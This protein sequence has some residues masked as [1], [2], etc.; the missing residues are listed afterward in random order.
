MGRKPL[1]IKR[2]GQA[3]NI[4][5]TLSEIGI[6]ATVRVI[7]KKS[8]FTPTIVAQLPK[9]D[10]AYCELRI[11]EFT[12]FIIKSEKRA[13]FFMSPE[14]VILEELA[15]S[16]W[17]GTAIIAI[18]FDLDEES[19]I[20]IF[21]NMPDGI[22]TTFINEGAYPSTFRPDNGAIICP[23]IIPNGYRQYITHVCCRMMSLYRIFQGDRILFSCFPQAT[24]VPELGWSYAEYDFFN[25]IMGESEK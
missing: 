1:S 10:T 11:R 8:G 7:A 15:L 20:R 21:A 9:A 5:A 18:P 23:G 16:K 19:Q 6:L 2:I 17:D 12:D 13:L 3:M 25:R 22:R 4:T 14:I 24:V